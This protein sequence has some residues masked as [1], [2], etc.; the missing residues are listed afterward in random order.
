MK[1]AQ[2]GCAA[3][4]AGVGSVSHSPMA[5]GLAPASARLRSYLRGV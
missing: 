3:S 1:K 5:T 2:W 4:S